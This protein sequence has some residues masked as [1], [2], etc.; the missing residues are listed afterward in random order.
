MIPFHEA[1]HPSSPRGHRTAP[2]TAAAAAAA[3]G[4][5]GPRGVDVVK[6]NLLIS[7]HVVGTVSHEVA[8]ASGAAGAAVAPAASAASAP[9]VTPAEDATGDTSL[10]LERARDTLSLAARAEASAAKEAIEAELTA[11]AIAQAAAA[12]IGP[13]RVSGTAFSSRNDDGGSGDGGDGVANGISN[14]R[15]TSARDRRYGDQREGLQGGDLVGG[16]GGPTGSVEGPVRSAGSIAGSP[17]QISFAKPT[18]ARTTIGLPETSSKSSGREFATRADMEEE[19]LVTRFRSHGHGDP[20]NA[21]VPS[22]AIQRPLYSLLG[23]PYQEAERHLPKQRR[24][25]THVAKASQ[26]QAARRWR[27]GWGGGDAVL[28]TFTSPSSSASG[29][30]PARKLQPVGATSRRLAS[31]PEDD[32]QRSGGTAGQA[33]WRS[34]VGSKSETASAIGGAG[35]EQQEAEW[36]RKLLFSGP[37]MPGLVLDLWSPGPIFLRHVEVGPASALLMFP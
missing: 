17:L 2:A 15:G 23:P 9:F 25:Q 14:S 6:N 32:V 8:S 31:F 35:E 37:G 28:T 34:E 3:D 11:T 26:G 13:S 16:S 30:V 20:L 7:R 5:F 33:A 12:A 21:P 27:G 18:N 19:E 29:P 22:I 10:G 24:G 4:T 36:V 1:D